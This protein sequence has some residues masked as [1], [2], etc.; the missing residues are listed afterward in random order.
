[1]PIRIQAKYVTNIFVQSLKS[2]Y[3]TNSNTDISRNNSAKHIAKWLFLSIKSQAD[4]IFTGESSPVM[5]ISSSKRVARFWWNWHANLKKNSCLSVFISQP[6][7]TGSK[8]RQ[9]FLPCTQKH[10]VINNFSTGFSKIC[11]CILVTHKV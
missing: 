1:M 9:K 3:K 8:K 5:I 11:A 2:A 4:Q 6:P 7:A 10:M